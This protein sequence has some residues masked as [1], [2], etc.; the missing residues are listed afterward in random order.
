MARRE[1]NFQGKQASRPCSGHLIH[2][3]LNFYGSVV[4]YILFGVIARGGDRW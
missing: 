2:L 4:N 1:A 3:D